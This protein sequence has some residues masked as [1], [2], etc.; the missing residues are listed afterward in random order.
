MKRRFPVWIDET[1]ALHTRIAVSAG[2][3]GMMVLLAPEDL[4]AYV[5][6][7]EA[8]LTALRIHR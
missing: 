4:K 1:A 5:G 3:R 6:A 7:Q 2:V 8:D